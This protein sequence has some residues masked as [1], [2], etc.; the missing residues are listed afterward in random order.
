MVE[1]IIVLLKQLLQIPE[2]Q[3]EIGKSGE[4]SVQK[5]L[6]AA[7]AEQNVFDLVVY[8][9]QEFTEPLQVKLSIH[10]LEI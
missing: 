6:L 8:L 1:L 5:R 9:T 2:D 4:R 10:F 7:Y 3:N